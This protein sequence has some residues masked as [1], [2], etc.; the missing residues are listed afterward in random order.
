MSKKCWSNKKGSL[1]TLSF[2]S[3]RTW[4]IEIELV[5]NRFVK[6]LL[7]RTFGIGSLDPP[8]K[9]YKKNNGE[10]YTQAYDVVLR[11]AHK[12]YLFG[13]DTIFLSFVTAI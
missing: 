3:K 5:A 4:R 13:K 7:N 12:I 10:K 1:S 2:G 11:K 8:F 9:L 6:K